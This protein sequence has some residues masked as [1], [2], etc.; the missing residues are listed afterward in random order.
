MHSEHRSSPHVLLSDPPHSTFSS[1]FFRGKQ[2]ENVL[3]GGRMEPY[4]GDS[5]LG[6]TKD[7]FSTSSTARV[8]N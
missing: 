4:R 6:K 3:H 1:S 7:G 8:R 5:R 2:Q